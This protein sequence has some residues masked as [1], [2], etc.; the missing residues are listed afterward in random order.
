MTASDSTGHIDGLPCYEG[1]DVAL[2][3]SHPAIMLASDGLM[4]RGQGHPRRCRGVSTPAV[5]V[6]CS[7]ED[8]LG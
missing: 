8:E 4:D 3:L 5:P 1:G 7:R 2:A 6:C